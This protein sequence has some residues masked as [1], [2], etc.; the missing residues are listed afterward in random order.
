MKNSFFTN[1]TAVKFAASVVLAISATTM[2]PACSNDS[3]AGT[4][5]QA[6]SI[7]ENESPTIPG[8]TSSSS[9]STGSPLLPPIIEGDSTP[10]IFNVDSI[11]PIIENNQNFDI[12]VSPADSILDSIINLDTLYTAPAFDICT[13]EYCNIDTR[14][15]IIGSKGTFY[16]QMWPWEAKVECEANDSQSSSYSVSKYGSTIKEFVS[17]DEGEVD[18][19]K[20]DC[21]AEGGNI[22]SDIFSGS[23]IPSN[24]T[25][26]TLSNA[27]EFYYY[28]SNWSKYS[29]IILSHCNTAKL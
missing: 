13:G 25:T 1:K 9:V 29:Q 20:Q 8:D 26:C 15:K 28:D 2:F 12:T 7:A 16:Y 23:D 11:P 18:M 24:S 14:K 6:N 22:G 19:F 5:E 4:D 21:I 10:P 27:D 3:V 17:L